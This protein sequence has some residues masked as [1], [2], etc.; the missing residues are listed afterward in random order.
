MHEAAE[1]GFE[2]GFWKTFS[3]VLPLTDIP[4]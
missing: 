4:R 1:V 2:L 3:I